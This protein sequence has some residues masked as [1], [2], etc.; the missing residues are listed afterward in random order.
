MHMI[1]NPA[2]PDHGAI[3]AHRDGTQV[4]VQCGPVARVTEK[5]PAFL[6]REDDVDK[7]I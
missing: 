5:G 7:Q 1:V 3:E 4:A 2:D 6:G